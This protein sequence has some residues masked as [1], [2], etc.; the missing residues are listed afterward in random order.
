MLQYATLD[1][2]PVFKLRADEAAEQESAQSVLVGASTVS[3]MTT[4]AACHREENEQA[5]YYMFR[6]GSTLEDMYKATKKGLTGKTFFT[7]DDHFSPEIKEVSGERDLNLLYVMTLND[8]GAV[9]DQEYLIDMLEA[10]KALFEEFEQNYKR[11]V[12]ASFTPYMFAPARRSDH[13]KICELNSIVV[14]ANEKIFGTGTYDPNVRLLRP[15]KAG[16]PG[17]TTLSLPDGTLANFHTDTSMRGSWI[18]PGAYHVSDRKLRQISKDMRVFMASGL[19]E[20]NGRPWDAYDIDLDIKLDEVIPMVDPN[21]QFPSLE[22]GASRSFFQEMDRSSESTQ[23]GAEASGDEPRPSRRTLRD[24]MPREAEGENRRKI[25]KNGSKDEE[26]KARIERSQE[27]R[28]NQAKE[29]AKQRAKERN[30]ASGQRLDA[31]SEIKGQA[32]KVKRS[33]E[34]ANFN[35]VDNVAGLNMA[36]SHHNISNN[37]ESS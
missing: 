4:Q 23:A 5:V 13:A 15:V 6:P 14:E 32:N 24:F 27:E 26:R 11:K 17:N 30:K 18:I 37:S 35:L 7:M 20:S 2:A 21:D 1:D 33:L 3:H 22:A 36:E 29:A 34:N 8:M 31:W 10:F 16:K 25:R 28:R 12:R 19:T 9:M